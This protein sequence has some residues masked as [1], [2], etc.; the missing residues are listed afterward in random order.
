MPNRQSKYLSS[1]GDRMA[2]VITEEFLWA[3]MS[4]W[5]E[6]LA[7]ATGDQRFRAMLGPDLERFI[8]NSINEIG[9]RGRA[10][11]A[12]G[13]ERPS[14]P[15]VQQRLLQIA[16]SITDRNDLTM[17]NRFLRSVKDGTALSQSWGEPDDDEAEADPQDSYAR[18]SAPQ[19]M[20]SAYGFGALE[21]KLDRGNTASADYDPRGEVGVGTTHSVDRQGAL[22]SVADTQLPEALAA[23]HRIVMPMTRPEGTHVYVLLEEMRKAVYYGYLIGH[24]AEGDGD[25][26]PQTNNQ[27][28]ATVNQAGNDVQPPDDAQQNNAASQSISTTQ[29]KSPSEIGQQYI[30]ATDAPFDYTFDLG[31]GSAPREASVV[32]NAR[33]GGGT[34]TAKEEQVL[35][36]FGDR[37][38]YWPVSSVPY[39]ESYDVRPLPAITDAD[40]ALYQLQQEGHRTAAARLQSPDSALP[41][42]DSNQTGNAVDLQPI[43]F[44]PSI[45][46]NAVPQQ[47]RIVN[48]NSGKTADDGDVD[49]DGPNQQFPKTMQQDLSSM[50]REQAMAMNLATA[51]QSL[52]NDAIQQS[53]LSSRSGGI[54]GGEDVDVPIT[55]GDVGR[56]VVNSGIG[57]VQ[58]LASQI[59]GVAGIEIS[60]DK[61]RRGD[62]TPLSTEQMIQSTPGLNMIYGLGSAE[63]KNY[64]EL[65][66]EINVGESTRATVT[67]L[68]TLNPFAVPVV[69]QSNELVNQGKPGEAIG[70][71]LGNVAALLSGTKGG[72]KFIKNVGVSFF[73]K[74]TGST[75][76]FGAGPIPEMT[77][78]AETSAQSGQPK[79]IPNQT[80]LPASEEPERRHR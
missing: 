63:K 13:A 49:V 31:G 15:T 70:F 56:G 59:P 46:T 72:Q 37:L 53:H 8:E 44:F 40:R 23:G 74:Q 32:F 45:G 43:S 68:S 14:P 2:G 55:A 19:S 73:P 34:A 47:A 52:H 54:F 5:R 28:S 75:T 36:N 10:R 80:N 51:R 50:T 27:G 57:L 18:Q 6:R 61:I 39:W 42:Q 25:T 17:F 7:A 33:D 20:R 21:S 77:F 78:P 12:G 22:H 9:R 66:D 4:Q 11:A 71:G 65:K 60:L 3:P 26:P 24:R 69:Q 38:E 1:M 35:F 58:G 79:S 41:V 76:L 62:W 29:Q 16:H 64:Q 30:T 48:A 67:G